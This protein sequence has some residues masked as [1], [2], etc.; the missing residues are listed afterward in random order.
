[1]TVQAVEQIAQA[2]IRHSQYSQ[3]G[4]EHNPAA[5]AALLEE[6]QENYPRLFAAIE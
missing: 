3:L 1:M 5:E 6:I 4:S 2:R